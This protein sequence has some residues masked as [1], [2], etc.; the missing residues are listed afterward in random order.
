MFLET[1][2][3]TFLHNCLKPE[4]V[5][6]FVLMLICLFGYAYPGYRSGGSLI[7]LLWLFGGVLAA[8]AW[9]LLVFA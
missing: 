1:L 7:Y 8:I 2:M 4:A 6:M 9:I 3:L 5:T